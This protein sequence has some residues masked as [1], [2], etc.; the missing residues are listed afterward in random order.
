MIRHTA[1]TD[2]NRSAVLAHLGA[3]GPSS[4]AELA[5]V[6]GV[7]PA[8]MTQLTKELLVDGLVVELDHEP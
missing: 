7:S 2:V 1:R 4:R 8:L 6:L 5:R 3:H